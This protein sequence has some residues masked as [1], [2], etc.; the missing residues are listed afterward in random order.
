MSELET[1]ARGAPRV[2][3]DAWQAG[4]EEADKNQ[5]RTKA[6][7]RGGAR[8]LWIG[9][10]FVGPIFLNIFRSLGRMR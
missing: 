3:K 7:L 2:L 10:K 8:G 5:S 1:I 4:A 6:A 9:L